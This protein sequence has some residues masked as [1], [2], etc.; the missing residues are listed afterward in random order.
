[1]SDVPFPAS[2]FDEWAE[3]YDESVSVNKFPF[4]RYRAVLEKTFQ[5]AKARGGM[6][7]L[8]LGTGTGNLAVLFARAGCELW[9]TDFSAAMLARARLKLP[10]A[11]FCLYDLHREWPDAIPPR[12]DRIVSAYVFHHFELEEKVRIILEL[13]NGHLAPDGRLVIA[14]IAFKDATMREAVRLE[15]GRDWEDEFYWI[16]DEIIPCLL[17]DGLKVKYIQVSPCAGVFSLQA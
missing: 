11:H 9:G 1:M 14:D 10:R 3:S 5:L 12:F 4:L 17:K 6:S 13:V 8:D 7:V 2:G 16:A 15:A